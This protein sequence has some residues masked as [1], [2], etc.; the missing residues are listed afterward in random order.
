MHNKALHYLVVFID[1]K[2][3]TS[4]KISNNSTIFLIECISFC[5]NL[6]VNIW[7][8]TNADFTTTE[9][10]IHE[11]MVQLSC[12]LKNTKRLC[13]LTNHYP[14]KY[15]VISY[16]G[17]VGLFYLNIVTKYWLECQM[18]HSIRWI[19]CFI[20]FSEWCQPFLFPSF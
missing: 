7:L 20:G 10:T 8:E 11:L 9:D 18:C 19:N 4:R 3:I 2:C 16:N 17:Q 12:P 15:S 14:V 1:N 6:A 13:S 5:Y